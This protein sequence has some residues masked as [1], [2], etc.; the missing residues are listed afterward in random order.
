MRAFYHFIGTGVHRASWWFRPLSEE[1]SFPFADW[2]ESAVN[3]DEN[4]NMSVD[5]E[6]V[7]HLEINLV[8]Q[9]EGESSEEDENIEDENSKD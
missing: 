9:P 6:S 7:E 2:N 1:F 5:Q 4:G 8:T 3:E